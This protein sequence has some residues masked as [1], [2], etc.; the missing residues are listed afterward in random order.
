MMDQQDQKNKKLDCF[1]L[2]C[3]QIDQAEVFHFIHTSISAQDR[4][5]LYISI[6][7]QDSQF[8]YVSISTQ[9]S[10]FIHTSISTQD[11]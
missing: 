3:I 11:R 6:S 5:F 8:L 7:T 9:D 2:F 10:Q 1:V 4:Q